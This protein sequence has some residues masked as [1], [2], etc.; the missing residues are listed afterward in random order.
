MENG[1]LPFLCKLS[2]TKTFQRISCRW[3]EPSAA[4]ATPGAG[5]GGDTVRGREYAQDFSLSW[6]TRRG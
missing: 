4:V 3:T 6:L 2:S 5:G 1:L